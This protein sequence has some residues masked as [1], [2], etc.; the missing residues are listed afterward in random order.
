MGIDMTIRSR[1]VATSDELARVQ[2]L[3]DGEAPPDGWQCIEE[4]VG[5]LC[6]E[7]GASADAPRYIFYMPK[8]WLSPSC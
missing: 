4:P 1:T 5:H 7:T 2:S 8:V 6:Q 3:V